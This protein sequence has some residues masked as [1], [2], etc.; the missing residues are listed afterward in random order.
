MTLSLSPSSVSENGG[1]STVTAALSHPSSEPSTVT[2][3][4]VA[5]LYTVG[6]DA[7]IVIAAGST[8]AATD[9][10]L[11][12]AV[13]DDVHQGSAV[14]SGTVTAT[15]ANGQGAGAVTG[16]ALTL[17]SADDLPLVSL[18][19]SPASISETGGR[20]TVTVRLSRASSEAVTVT[21][22]ASAGTGAVAADFAQVGTT[23]TIAAG[24]TA[25][26]GTVT[27]TAYSN[28]VHSPLDKAVRGVRHGDGRQ[29]RG[30]SA[31]R[32]PDP[33]GGRRGADGGRWCSRRAR[34]RRRAGSRW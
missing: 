31:E 23:L 28:A 19:L 15:L 9:T 34:L 2:V 21:V 13:R 17:E 5:G 33:G 24:S 27:V 29:R 11:V 6:S 7:T 22:A 30:G 10:V 1:V 16:A 20:S 14:R 25:S 32:D 12:T 4:A 18:L 3:T 8:T 26:T